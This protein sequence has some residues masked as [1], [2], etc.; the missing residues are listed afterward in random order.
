MINSPIFNMSREGIIVPLE[1]KITNVVYQ[2]SKRETDANLNA[3]LNLSCI[4]PPPATSDATGGI[5]LKCICM[6]MMDN[7][8]I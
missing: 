1:W 5:Y 8:H 6:N 7:K 4:K 2:S 3:N